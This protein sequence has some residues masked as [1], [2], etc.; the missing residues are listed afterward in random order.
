MHVKLV[1]VYDYFFKNN[2]IAEDLEGL[3]SFLKENLFIPPFGVILF[4]FFNSIFIL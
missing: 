4:L 3:V 2:I 1:W